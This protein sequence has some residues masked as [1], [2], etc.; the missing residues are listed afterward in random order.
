MGNGVF[1]SVPGA[2][3]V[4]ATDTIGQNA[5]QAQGTGITIFGET[6][7]TSTDSFSFGSVVGVYGLGFGS[8]GVTGFG[9]VTGVTGF[10]FPINGSNPG[11]GVVGL[12]GDSLSAASAVFNAG[13]G[14]LGVGTVGVSGQGTEAGVIGYSTGAGPGVNGVSSSSGGTGGLF[15]ATS[16]TGIGVQAVGG[17][18]VQTSPP[19]PTAG[20]FAEGGLGPGVYA[21]SE[22]GNA[23]SG[24]SESGNGVSGTSNTGAGISGQS[25]SSTGVLAISQSG[26][27]ILAQSTNG[28]GVSASSGSGVGVSASSERS[29]AVS[30]LCLGSSVGVD[31][32]SL[33]GIG[34]HALGGGASR[35][36]PSP[37]TQAAIFAEGGPGPG[38]YATSDGI[39][40][41]A[42]GGST[43]VGLQVIGK[44][45]VQGNSVG[46]V[47]MAA[48]T[49]TMTVNNPAATAN[50]LIFLTPLDN[51]QEFLWISIRKEGSFTIGASKALPTKVTIMF[52]IIN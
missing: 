9:T 2:P 7:G 36:S 3:A 15:Q 38:V 14:V 16:P 47:T 23:V 24:T 43:G 22:T 11:N 44:V 19:I 32:V 20:I 28:T 37:I 30:A 35:A 12:S 42:N 8:N 10:T 18:A 31:A 13:N 39:G 4:Q 52:L 48:G 40:V 5:I 6:T 49:E 27:G 26:D 50:S 34:V 33:S 41:V 1:N 29:F 21:T 51:P 45:E 25:T 46:S 17:G